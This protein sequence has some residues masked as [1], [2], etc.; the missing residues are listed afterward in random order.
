MFRIVEINY[1]ICET[2]A[3]Y[4]F[5][6]EIPIEFAQIEIEFSHISGYLP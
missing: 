6:W 2:V 3:S 5:S 4:P 1:N